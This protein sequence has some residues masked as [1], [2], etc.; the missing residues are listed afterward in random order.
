MR[1]LAII[2]ALAVLLPI[3]VAAPSPARAWGEFGHLTVCDL[4]YRNFTPTT[5]EVLKQL[6]NA[7][8]GITV[9]EDGRPR[10]YTS[11]NV[12]CLEED[13]RPRAH[14]SDHFINVPRDMAAITG[15]N[16]PLS[17]SSGQPVKCILSGIERDRAILKDTARSRQDRVIALMAIGHWVGDIHQPLHISFKDDTGGNAIGVRFSGKCGVG[18][19]GNPYRPGSFHAVWDNCLLENGIFQRVRERADYS[20]NW[21]RRTITY[22]AVDTLNANT[23]ATERRQWTQSEPWQWAAESYAITKQPDVQYCVMAGNSCQYSSTDPVLADGGTEK[24]VVIDAAYLNQFKDVAG[25][26]VRKAGIR[27]A[28]IVN[29]AL[30]P[31]YSGF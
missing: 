30:D 1:S 31:A 23:S 3:E 21:S 12:G 24:K 29:S 15:P 19:T 16:C 26:R 2:P 28:H 25:E 9:N 18:S 10:H 20:S 6:F 5:R 22:R 13:E 4:A 27:L 14:P 17:P 11:F 7:P 8:R